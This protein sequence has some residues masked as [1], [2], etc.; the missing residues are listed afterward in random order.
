MRRAT[1]ILLPSLTIA[2]LAMAGFATVPMS[3]AYAQS[4][5]PGIGEP[6]KEVS[7]Q[8]LDQAAAAIKQVVTVKE[9]YQQRIEAAAPTDRER[10]AD[11]GK[12]ALEKAVT[13]QGLSLTEYSSILVIAQS[14]PEVKEKFLQ[15]LI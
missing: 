14:D 4:Q 3:N 15:R 10:L 13:D 11:E 5:S 7:D 2:T 6:M 12:A 8:K 9:D 1:K